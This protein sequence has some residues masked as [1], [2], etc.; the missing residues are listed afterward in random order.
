MNLVKMFWIVKYF[1]ENRSSILN[2]LG[3]K[4][5]KCQFNPYLVPRNCS[6]YILCKHQPY[7]C[8]FLLIFQAYILL[9][10]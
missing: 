4:S 8:A 3:L 5:K 2:S 7:C 1:W 6:T 10:S 9:I